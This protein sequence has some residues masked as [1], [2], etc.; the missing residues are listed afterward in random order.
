[1][2]VSGT[3]QPVADDEPVVVVVDDAI[4]PAAAAGRIRDLSSRIELVES[5]SPHALQRAHVVFTMMGSFDPAHAP[6]LR[7]VQTE[8]ASIAHLMQTKLAASSIPV[9]NALG[10]LSPNVAELAIG[11]MLT[12]TRRLAGCHRLQAE[13]RWPQRDEHRA[14]HGDHC[15]GKT[16]GILGYGSIGRQIARIASGLGMRILACNRSG[17]KRKCE[18][19]C[20]ANTGDAEG[21]LP[22]R[23]YA[24][25]QLDQM[26]PISDVVVLCLPLTTETRHFIG[27]DQLRLLGDHALLIDVGRG[28]VLDLEALVDCLHTGGLAGAALDVYE[29]EPLP[30]EHPLWRAPNLVMSPHI[31]AG[32]KN[33]NEFVAEVLAENLSRFLD[34]RPLINLVD[35]QR[36]Y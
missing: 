19:F 2:E 1:M 20:L 27:A 18:G 4:L 11:M 30:S 7:W 13:Q 15:Y 35:F 21:D 10:A 26:L 5:M 14:L 8:S 24:V 22:A 9:V 25:A 6:R 12:L 36:G 32:T 29:Q 33:R 28:G 34:H 16:L 23:W 3:C 31:G 17:R